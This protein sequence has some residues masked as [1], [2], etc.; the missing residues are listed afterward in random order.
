[1]RLADIPQTYHFS[2][3]TQAQDSSIRWVYLG[4]L[5]SGLDFRH[6]LELEAILHPWSLANLDEFTTTGSTN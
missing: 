2:V 5:A 6:G 1:M 4:A 3:R